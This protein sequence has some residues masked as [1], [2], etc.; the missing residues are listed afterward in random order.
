MR[1][2]V[3]T[4]LLV[5]STP[6][7][8]DD[9]FVATFGSD[10]LV[11][12]RVRAT[13]LDKVFVEKK[14]QADAFGWS[15]AQTLW[16]LYHDAPKIQLHKIVDGKV[17][18]KVTVPPTAFK[19]SGG[20][21]PEPKLRITTKGE[22][23]LEHCT[24]QKGDT[25]DDSL[26]CVKGTWVRADTKDQKAVTK[27]P[28]GIDD[29]RVSNSGLGTAPPFPK[30]KTPAGYTVTLQ[31][32]TVDGL[33][34]DQKKMKTKGAVC[35][36]PASSKTWPDNT[37]DIPFSMKPSRVTWIRT[38]P[39]VAVIDGQAKNPIGEIEFHQ[40]VFLECKDVFDEARYFGG[41][42]WGLRDQSQW[43]IWHE[44]KKLGTINAD[45]L[46]AAPIK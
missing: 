11:I 46:R 13:G 26:R 35:K 8:A 43:T 27:K 6:A 18:E 41:G 38:Q 36:G 20:V 30:A 17:T 25:G 28:A 23:W 39:A 9:A 4:L 40:A 24:K 10:E 45:Y 37:V 1:I 15:D 29:F 19:L 34:D 33:G 31:Q 14:S 16:V 42:A 22:I 2:V 21:E 5:L 44:D 32:V 3:A 7:A 12:H